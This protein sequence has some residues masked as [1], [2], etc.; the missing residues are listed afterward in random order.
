MSKYDD[1]IKSISEKVSTT[2]NR[3]HSNSDLVD[4][5]AAMLNEPDH[6]VTKVIATDG[7]KNFNK[8]ETKPVEEYRA[9]IE[10]I[11]VSEFGVSKEEAAK[12]RTMPLSKSH[13]KAL[14]GV[15]KPVIN[16][17]LDTGRKFTMDVADENSVK[18]SIQKVQLAEKTEATTKIVKDEA[19][20]KY[21]Q[22]P[23]GK[24]IRTAA[25]TAL[26]ASN[27]VPAYLKKEV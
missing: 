18:M 19:T 27:A 23:T 21:V 16:D 1:L 22:V 8:V 9:E 12:A 3:S 26:K 4:I 24:T 15:A 6:V 25:R 17:Y 5:T 20:G 7:G 11:V 14:M 10:K 13:A 2:N